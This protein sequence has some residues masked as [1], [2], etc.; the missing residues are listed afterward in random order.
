[1]TLLIIE[2]D[3]DL[4]ELF[5]DQFEVRGLTVFLAE[6]GKVG[7]EIL[8]SEEIDLV[9]TDIQ[10]PI[11][12]G[13]EFLKQSKGLQKRLPPIVVMTGGSPYTSSQLY[14]EGASAYLDKISLSADKVLGYIKKSA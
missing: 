2:D 12:N 4:R 13:F 9:L 11:M 10:M 14:A 6:N 1:M 5:R 7:L 8:K 3:K